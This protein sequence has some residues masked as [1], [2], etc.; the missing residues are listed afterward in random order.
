[1]GHERLFLNIAIPCTYR[2]TR[3]PFQYIGAGEWGC[4]IICTVAQLTASYRVQPSSQFYPA[5]PGPSELRGSGG[6]FSRTL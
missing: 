3:A 5:L 4:Y 6:D 1:M 2:A